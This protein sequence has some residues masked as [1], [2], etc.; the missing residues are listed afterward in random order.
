MTVSPTMAKLAGRRDERTAGAR[1]AVRDRKPLAGARIGD[2]RDHVP[3]NLR[4]STRCWHHGPRHS[5]PDL[6]AGCAALVRTSDMVHLRRQQPSVRFRA[7]TVMQ[8]LAE[9]ELAQP[10]LAHRGHRGQIQSDPAL[11]SRPCNLATARRSAGRAHVQMYRMVVQ[12]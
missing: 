8:C 3:E 6:S 4:Q 11:T 10:H 2:V 12:Q 9:C 1:V 7:K 5:T